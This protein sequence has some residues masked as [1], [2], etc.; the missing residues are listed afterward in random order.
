MTLE[1][2]LLKVYIDLRTLLMKDFIEHQE[3]NI[4]VSKL[5]NFYGSNLLL[6][7]NKLIMVVQMII[8]EAYNSA[9]SKS[10]V[11]PYLEEENQN[12]DKTFNDISIAKS[13]KESERVEKIK[14]IPMNFKTPVKK[15]ARHK[16]SSPANAKGIKEISYILRPNRSSAKKRLDSTNN[17]TLKLTDSSTCF[18][19]TSKSPSLLNVILSNRSFRAFDKVDKSFTR[20]SS[21]NHTLILQSA[22]LNPS[23][24]SHK[25]SVSSP[26]QQTVMS[27]F[28]HIRGHVSFSNANR[29]SWVDVVAKTDSPGPAK[30][31]PQIR[32][33]SPSP[34]IGKNPKKSWVDI[35]A[36]TDSPGPAKYNVQIRS[37]F[38]SPTI[39]KAEKISW[40]DVVAKI[41]L[42]G[43]A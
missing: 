17:T 25:P 30:Y 31:N 10:V 27:E 42:L 20:N 41:D 6:F 18:S 26:K 32:S 39:P 2:S 40:V 3:G 13:T 22:M 21:P 1:T 4:E 43:F 33:R 11:Q 28:N 5:K 15:S 29:T 14:V 35:A 34:T 19:P 38:P 23:F 12:E 7:K 24:L 37:R 8:E 36:Q 16:D 9:V